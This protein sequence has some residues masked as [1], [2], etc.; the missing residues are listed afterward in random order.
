MSEIPPEDL[1]KIIVRPARLRG[2]E[3][4]VVWEDPQVCPFYLSRR[5]A[6]DS[7]IGRGTNGART[8][9]VRNSAGAII[10]QIDGPGLAALADKRALGY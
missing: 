4:W 8:L 6:I 7:A 10:R 9:E 3:G 1:G 5:Q 2:Q